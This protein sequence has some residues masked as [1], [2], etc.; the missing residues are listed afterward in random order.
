M[1]QTNRFTH[2]LELYISGHI[3][4]DE[5]AE[6]F[7]LLS[8]HKYDDL[9]TKSIHKDLAKDSAWLAA[10]LPPHV[11][12]DMV[13]N[14]FNAEKNT[15]K[16]LPLRQAK[17]YKRW[18]VAASIL[19]IA[20]ISGYFILAENKSQ[21]FNH[22]FRALIPANPVIHEN[23]ESKEQVIVLED[24]SKVT[25]QPH[26]TLHYAQPFRA[27]KR[28]VFLEGEAFFEVTKNP[29]KPFLV[30]YNNIVTRVLGTSF[31]V[32]TNAQTGDIEVAVKSGKVQVYENESLLKDRI[33]KAIILTPNQKLVYK[34]DNR[35]FETLL[36]EKPEPLIDESIR[37]EIAGPYVYD[38]EKLVNVF[39]HLELTYGIEIVLDNPN[40][41]NCVFTG[42]VSSQDL[43]TK[44]KIICL[45][46]NASYEINGTKIL[47]KGKGCPIN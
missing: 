42:D 31:R 38:Q 22:S 15:S 1:S 7:E 19:L 25:L 23:D 16:I 4:A 9:L 36:V 39:S 44:L 6:L 29:S 2:L 11:A 41:N 12:E 40:L 28:E 30:Y 10:D 21:R 8:T 37:G 43:Y 26:S 47:I 24:G 17:S 45:T 32:N 27:D 5:H 20:G 33:N 13:R 34:P 46:T 35:L 3:S 14:I 18:L